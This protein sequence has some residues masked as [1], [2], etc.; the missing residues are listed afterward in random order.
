METSE[1]DRA[2]RLENIRRLEQLLEESEQDR[3]TRLNV[4]QTQGAQVADLQARLTGPT[5]IGN[6]EADQVL[7]NKEIN[8]QRSL[9]AKLVEVG[10]RLEKEIVSLGEQLK[11]AGHERDELRTALAGLQ[12]Q[13]E[14]SEADRVSR[15]EEIDQLRRKLEEADFKHKRLQ[16]EINYSKAHAGE[17]Q[18]TLQQLGDNASMVSCARWVYGGP[19][20]QCGN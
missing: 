3:A 10:V 7:R 6:L 15:G 20:P 1:L 16:V 4:I 18:T 19:V 12:Q 13:L 9:T 5:A 11:T 2:T 17:M 8:E 14:L